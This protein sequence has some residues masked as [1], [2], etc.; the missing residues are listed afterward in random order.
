M[1][2]LSLPQNP[3][4]RLN[5]LARTIASLYITLIHLPHLKNSKQS[6]WALLAFQYYRNI[7]DNF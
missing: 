6:K 5:N 4:W 1:H 2:G 3:K 7:G